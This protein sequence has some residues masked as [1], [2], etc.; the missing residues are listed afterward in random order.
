MR[1]SIIFETEAIL[2]PGAPSSWNL[3]YLNL[4]ATG[5]TNLP[6]HAFLQQLKSVEEKLGRDLG[7]PKWAPRVI[8]LDILTW[9]DQVIDTEILQIPHPELKNRPFL[10]SLMASLEPQLETNPTPKYKCFAPVPLLMGIVNITPDSFSDGGRY[11]AAEK[12]ME[13][14]EELA[15]EGA[16]II[17]LGAQSTRPGAAILSAEEEWARLEPV[18]KL[19]QQRLQNR[20]SFPPISLDTFQPQV[21]EKALQILQID[22]LNDVEGGKN[23][24]LLEVAREAGCKV[25][26]THSLTVPASKTALL[27]NDRLPSAH[28]HEWGKQKIEQLQKWGIPKEKILLDPGIGFGKSAFQSLELLRTIEGLKSLGC[29]IL[30]GHSRKSFLQ[31]LRESTDRDVETL[32]ISH[33]LAKQGVSYLRVHNVEAHHRA[34]TAYALASGGICSLA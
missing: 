14:I 23:Q 15:S 11:L 9:D 5:I 12:A 18:L 13:R 8:D 27:P 19:L 22:Y 4:V 31:I 21:L 28:L 30:V 16:A 2:P 29:E 32:A 26:L 6:P 33:Y 7:A 3:P 1:T 34:L 17:D 10:L 25:I 24:R 20:L